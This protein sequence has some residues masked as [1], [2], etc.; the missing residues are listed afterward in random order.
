[1][2]YFT[3][4]LYYNNIKHHHYPIEFLFTNNIFKH[5]AKLVSNRPI[6]LLLLFLLLLLLLFC[7]LFIYFERGILSLKHHKKTR[8]SQ[9]HISSK[10]RNKIINTQKQNDLEYA[11]QYKY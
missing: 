3:I 7:Y 2:P 11:T 5:A 10:L 8:E 9:S 4:I 6:E 1:M